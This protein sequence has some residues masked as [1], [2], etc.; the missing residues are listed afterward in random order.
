MYGQISEA[1]ASLELREEP[2]RRTED[3]HW[4]C[5]FLDPYRDGVE[6]QVKGSDTCDDWESNVK[7]AEAE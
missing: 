1:Q 6:I 4:V 5:G 3:Q 2:H 7:A